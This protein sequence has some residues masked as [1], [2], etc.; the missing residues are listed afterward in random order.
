MNRAQFLKR[1]GAGTAAVSLPAVAGLAHARNAAA[2]AALDD[3]SLKDEGVG[4]YTDASVANQISNF[5]INRSLV[6]CGVGTIA[7]SIENSGEFAM[8]MYSTRIRSYKA[9]HQ[10]KKITATGRMR[11]ITRI[12]GSTVEDVEH[13][14]IAIAVDTGADKMDRFDVHFTTPFW[15]PTGAGAAFCTPSTV[16]AGWCRFGGVLIRDPSSGEEQFGDIAVGP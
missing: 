1:A 5:T 2:A 4:T 3:G 7:P 12:N 14:F 13:D 16:H 11:S 9:D 10:T 15:S 8:L 6:S